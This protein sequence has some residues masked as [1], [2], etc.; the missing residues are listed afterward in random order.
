M[1]QTGHS[2]NIGDFKVQKEAPLT[3]IFSFNRELQVNCALTQKLAFFLVQV[4]DEFAF[5]KVAWDEALS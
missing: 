3:N 5:E 4:P 2:R 1:T